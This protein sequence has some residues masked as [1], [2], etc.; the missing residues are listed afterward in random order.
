MVEVYKK[1]IFMIQSTEVTSASL[2]SWTATLPSCSVN[3]HTAAC[4]T[5][6]VF[7]GSGAPE[8]QFV[9]DLLNTSL[10]RHAVVWEVTLQL[11]S[12]AFQDEREAEVTSV[13]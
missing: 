4:L 5:R 10:V 12:V 1:F 6:D 8:M 11:G 7:R 3:S 9:S 2:S 13:D